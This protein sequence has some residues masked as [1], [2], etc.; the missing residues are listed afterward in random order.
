LALTRASD[1]EWAERARDWYRKLGYNPLPGRIDAKAPWLA[2][3]RQYQE[4]LCLEW[5]PTP[6]VVLML[7]VRWGLVVLD[8]DGDRSHAWLTDNQPEDLPR[9]WVTHNGG[10]GR[11]VWFSVPPG[12]ESIPSRRLWSDPDEDHQIVEIL[13]DNHIVVVPPS[14]HPDRKTRYEFAPGCGP[15]DIPRP[16]PIPGWLI[17]LASCSLGRAEPP[18]PAPRTDAA[19]RNEGVHFKSGEVAA[20]MAGRWLDEA[21]TLGLKL[22]G[23]RPSKSGWIKAFRVSRTERRPSASFNAGTGRYWEP[24]L[25]SVSF[26]TMAQMLNSALFPS[27]Q[28]AVNYFGNKYIKKS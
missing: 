8:L 7:G 12:V 14:I 16:A 1:L 20:A 25:G 9:T 2:S 6:N 19:F 11:H 27:W 3:Y 15:R 22:A 13:G 26:F 23:S 21:L 18:K 17:A 5:R 10:S 24:E 28:Y 4:E